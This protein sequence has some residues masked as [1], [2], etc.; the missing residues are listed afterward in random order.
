MIV[1]SVLNAVGV[2]SPWGRVIVGAG[3]AALMVS[4]GTAGALGSLGLGTHVALSSALGAGAAAAY[5]AR[6]HRSTRHRS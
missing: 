6:V 4:L 1:D 2:R 5:A 3:L